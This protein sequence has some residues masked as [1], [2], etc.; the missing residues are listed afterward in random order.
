MVVACWMTLALPALAA[1]VFFPAT[2]AYHRRN[3]D[4]FD[5]PSP[6]PVTLATATE[7]VAPAAAAAAS[8]PPSSEVRLLGSDPFDKF[9]ATA[10]I[11][12]R[13]N[14]HAPPPAAAPATFQSAFQSA[15]SDWTSSTFKRIPSSEAPPAM[16]SSQS[17]SSAVVPAKF[18]AAPGNPPAAAT[19]T[20]QLPT[21]PGAPPTPP[22][23]LTEADGPDE[24]GAQWAPKPLADLTT[25]TTLP[26]G[27]LPR[28]YWSER[29]P[30]TIAFFDPNGTTRGW[31]VNTYN[32]V[33]SCLAHNPLYFEEI[34]LERYGY[35]CSAGGPCCTN[36]VQS[37]CSAAHFF[38]TV[39]A[40]PYMMAVDCP[41]ECDYT[42]GYYRPGSCPPWQRNCCTRC[43]AL[44]GL[45]A[46][47]AAIGL[48]FLIP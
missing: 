31:P 11:R 17:E 42:L 48:I 3:Y 23:A 25:N 7:E 14:E 29:S 46:S 22:S 9:D 13:F 47:G 44:G 18:L 38:G 41:G 35:G 8:S 39:P 32:W 4:P 15:P 21:P 16:P 6:E 12:T 43:S 40:L 20:E 5:Q 19:V 37:L 36:G 2:T 28:D 1:D 27:V 34:N 10:A 24:P 33:A 30:Q 45:S 26:G